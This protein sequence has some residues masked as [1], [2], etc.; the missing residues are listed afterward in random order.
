MSKHG[1]IRRY[2][3]I[4]EKIGR[5]QFPSFSIIKEYLFE[6]GFEVSARTIQRDI[7]QIR[8]DFGI[9]IKYD[10]TRNGYYIDA[11]TSINTDS[12]LR[13][14]EIVNTAELLTN[15]L[16]ESRNT[17]D[18]ISFESLGNLRGVEN[19]KPL[20]FAIKNNRKIKFSH[21]NFETGETKKHSV[22]P[23]LLKEYQNR[24]YIIGIIGEKE[25][26]RT[27]GID[28]IFNLEVKEEVFQIE[29]KTTPNQLFENTIGLTYSLKN[30]E[31]VILSFTP[32]QGKY[33]KTLPMHKSQIILKDDE[34]ELLIKLKIIPNYEFEQKILM[35][36]EAV[37]VIKPKWL[38][39]NIKTSL[40]TT[41]N[42]YK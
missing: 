37:K 41:L 4:I 38:V 17:L 23:Y 27:F 42:K 19:L 25:E 20:L 7:E 40:Q 33:V 15:S 13:F 12:L 16:K 1:S 6:Q 8:F 29:S 14:L 5:N 30:I 32:L 10:R 35:L 3:L 9:E 34:N 39:D 21:E 28:R 31:E 24:W 18:Y 2:T 26:F 22:N 11:E 36:G